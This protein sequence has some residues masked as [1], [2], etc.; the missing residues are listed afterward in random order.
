MESSVIGLSQARDPKR[1]I[2]NAA[3]LF[4]SVIGRTGTRAAS[5]A[6]TGRTAADVSVFLRNMADSRVLE[7]PLKR[8][9]VSTDSVQV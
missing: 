9:P 2:S 7:I 4:S 6:E 3:R 8:R 1:P 5:R